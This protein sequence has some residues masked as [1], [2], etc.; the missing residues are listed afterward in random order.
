[1]K[2]NYRILFIIFNVL[3]ILYALFCL[4][5][6]QKHI[7]TPTK[8]EIQVTSTLFKLK[9]FN[10]QTNKEIVELFVTIC[11][12]Y[13][14]DLDYGISQICYESSAI[15]I[16]NNN[17][18][19]S[20]NGAI[21]ISQIK[22]ILSYDILRN[23]PKE[24]LQFLIDSLNCTNPNFIKKD[25]KSA[26]NDAKNWLKNINNNISLWGY[27]MKCYMDSGKTYEQSLITYNIGSGGYRI[28]KRN[29]LS[30]KSHKYVKNIFK[31]REKL[32]Q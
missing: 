16:K 32:K 8:H 24:E 15:H 3:L 5:S 19:I 2:I 18:I 12:K 13:D 23:M 1:M 30:P 17:V 25:Y 27:I 22:P 11:E 31:I 20:K 4:I 6:S 21:G 10:P 29:K 26:R 9:K 7:K 28:W 14:L